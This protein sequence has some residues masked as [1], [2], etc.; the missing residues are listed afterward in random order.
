VDNNKHIH[1]ILE[2][3]YKA[4]IAEVKKDNDKAFLKKL[5]KNQQYWLLKIISN[6][7]SFKAIVTVLATSLVKK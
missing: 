7:E 3:I 4:A 2:K 5:N 6:A 1:Q